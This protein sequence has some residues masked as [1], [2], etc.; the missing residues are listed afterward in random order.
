MKF[1]TN[2]GSTVRSQTIKKN[3]SVNVPDAPEREGF[4]FRGWYSDIN[5]TELYDFESKVKSNITLYAKWEESAG[6]GG[7]SYVDPGYSEPGFMEPTPF[8]PN[9]SYDTPATTGESLVSGDSG[10]AYVNGRSAGKFAPNAGITRGEVAAI[11]YRLMSESAKS[12]YYSQSNYFTDVDSDSWYNE[13]ISTL[14]EAGVLSGYEDGSFRPDQP[15]TRA[16]LAAILVRVQGNGISE[17]NTTFSDTNGHWAE[18][19]IASAVTAGLVYG[20][21]DGSFRPNRSITRAEA[22]T[23]MNRLLMRSPMDSSYVGNVSFTDVQSSDW[24]YGDVMAAAN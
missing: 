20:Y 5:L 19:Y 11:I 12:R 13:A 2:G 24:F 18:G 7:P 17:G 1:E 21:E 22:V 3:G 10:I 14:V 9:S 4:I 8:D 15:V 6:S 16:E 23:M